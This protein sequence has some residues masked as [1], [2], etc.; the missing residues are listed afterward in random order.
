MIIAFTQP[1]VFGASFICEPASVGFSGN[2]GHPG[3]HWDGNSVEIT[4]TN[5]RYKN[6]A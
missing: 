6:R 2:G 5:N 3:Q 1:V 4:E